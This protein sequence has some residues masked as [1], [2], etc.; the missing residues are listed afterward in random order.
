MR[1]E[2]FD[3]T[4]VTRGHASLPTGATFA[5]KG[6]GIVGASTLALSSDGLVSEPISGFEPR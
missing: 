4:S 2:T 3:P 5:G 6:R 1:Y